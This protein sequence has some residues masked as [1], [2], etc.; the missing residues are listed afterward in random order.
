MLTA[1]FC[2]YILTNSF[3]NLIRSDLFLYSIDVL[4]RFK[5]SILNC[6]S[7][8]RHCSKDQR[9]SVF[10]SVNEDVQKSCQLH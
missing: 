7:I 2:D 9:K 6:L 10:G 5:V 4:L 1:E 3:M 8:K